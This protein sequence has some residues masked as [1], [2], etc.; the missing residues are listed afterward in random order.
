MNARFGAVTLRH[1]DG[2]GFPSDIPVIDRLGS[3]VASAERS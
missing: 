3:T 2:I 1:L